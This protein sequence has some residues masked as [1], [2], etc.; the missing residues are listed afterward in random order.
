MS[1]D[2][3]DKKYDVR[4]I[5]VL[6]G[7][8][9]V[10][11]RPGMYIGNTEDGTGLHHMIYEVLDNSIDEALAGY[12]TRIE[13]RIMKDNSVSV[14]DNG[15]GI[16]IHHHPE[17]KIPTPQVIFTVLH[18]GGKFDQDSYSISGGLH[19]VGLSVVNAL[20]DNL[21][22][23]VKRDNLIYRQSFTFGDPAPC[24]YGKYEGSDTGTYIRFLP[25]KSI[26]KNIKFDLDILKNRFQE[27]VYLNK[28]TAINL[29]DER[30]VEEFAFSSS[31]GIKDFVKSVGHKSLIA[32]SYT[33]EGHDEKSSTAAFIA[34]HWGVKKHD[35]K[36]LCYTNNIPQPDGGT[37]LIGFKA[38]LSKAFFKYVE[39]E[40]KIKHKVTLTPEDVRAGLV[41]IVSVHTPTPMFSSQTKEKLVNSE[42]R[43]AVDSIVFEKMYDYLMENSQIAEA[44]ID[45]MYQAAH[46]R[47]AAKNARQLNKQVQ[48]HSIIHS[49]T[50][51][52]AFCKETN[53]EL[54]EIFLV[55][56]DS[57]A[58]PAK[59]ARLRNT[60]AV[61]PLRGKILN[62][63]KSTVDNMMKS[64]EIL[65]IFSSLGV[66]LNDELSLEKLKY[67]KIILMTDADVDGR[68]INTLL[69]TLFY[70][71]LRE[72]VENGYLYLAQP[73]LYQCRING[74]KKYLRDD[75]HMN[76]V[77][78]E[79]TFQN[80]YILDSNG[81]KIDEF[82]KLLSMY[83][84]IDQVIRG[85]EYM[86]PRQILVAI[87]NVPHFSSCRVDSWKETVL[88]HLKDIGRV[89]F[90]TNSL[91]LHHSY[92]GINYRYDLNILLKG[93]HYED[94]VKNFQYLNK[95]QQVSAVIS[96]TGEVLVTNSLF[97]TLRSILKYTRDFSFKS[98]KR[99]KGLGE[100]NVDE[101][102]E[103]TMNPQ[104]RKIIKVTVEDAEKADEMF[105]ILMGQDVEARKE[106][107]VENSKFVKINL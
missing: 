55:E 105:K 10:K 62:V 15:R 54:C 76:A 32:P 23:E 22:V 9:A 86:M 68:H 98:L 64:T 85:Y 3:K 45:H 73:P 67:H 51:K 36:L 79:V 24:S 16:P 88:S 93:C 20:S 96:K 13:V 91:T 41:A 104:T 27:I 103:S 74:Q 4:H 44:L 69:L 34:L 90:E 43:K 63:A 12:C 5:K 1:K 95:F 106:F 82:E 94:L 66:S 7:L 56:G 11:M 39:K 83:L 92:N 30:S 97:E 75:S 2:S 29:F 33:I 14:K 60:Q 77:C 38:G 87:G 102:W 101:L 35:D 84:D 48:S 61:L 40:C 50:G 25:S 53:P 42:I 18:S 28:G 21:F 8:E 65:N 6:K 100:M 107:I 78:N 81:K 70:Q 99:F 17:E 19:G 71:H 72:V 31:E 58:G 57:A 46:S 47:L 49:M 89:E 52:L 80:F 26:F 59:Q 37:H